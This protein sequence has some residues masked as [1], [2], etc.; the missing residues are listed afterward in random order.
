[1]PHDNLQ[2]ARGKER[3]K[4]EKILEHFVENPNK[5]FTPQEVAKA[6]D[7]DRQTTTTLIKRLEGEGILEKKGRGKYVYEDRIDAEVAKTA[8]LEIINMAAITIGKM[9]IDRHLEKSKELDDDDPRAAMR[10]L[11]EFL[12]EKFGDD[13]AEMIVESAIL[14]NFPRDEAKKILSI[15]SY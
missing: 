15:L 5:I 8:Y 7:F 14:K 9:F 6:L 3:S 11:I 13:F 2:R 4:T 1:M 10:K 12:R